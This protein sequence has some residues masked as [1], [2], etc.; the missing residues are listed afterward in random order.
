MP[1]QFK[2][3]AIYGNFNPENCDSPA[4]VG[5]PFLRQN[6]IL[7]KQERQ[8]SF[9]HARQHIDLRQWRKILPYFW[10]VLGA[11]NSL[12]NF[13]GSFFDIS[14]PALPPERK[15]AQPAVSGQWSVAHCHISF[16]SGNVNSLYAGEDAGR[17]KVHFL[18]TQMR[19]F[20]F[21]F[22]GLQETR[23][24]EICS[25][26]D[27]VYRLGGG[28]DHGHWGTELWIDLA[29]PIAYVRKQPIYLSKQDFVVLFKSPSLHVYC[30]FEW[31]IGCGVHW[32][33]LLMRHKVDNARLTEPNG[34]STLV[35]LFN[36]FMTGLH[37][38]S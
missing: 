27:D 28:A 21:N 1:P 17:G 36:N 25:C 32:L 38:S 19:Q 5:V 6:H 23:C 12:Q 34:G 22:L 29:R 8:K 26:V 13:Q 10:M 14:P 35:K 4:D 30:W 18:R 7:A 33:S 24:A 3:K 15:A 9:Y 37:F 31:I 11:D 16:A 20:G 2:C